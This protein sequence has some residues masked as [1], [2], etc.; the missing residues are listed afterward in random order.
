M[1]DVPKPGTTS[2]DIYTIL[3]GVAA[4]FVLIATVVT[5]VQHYRF[6]GTVIEFGG[7]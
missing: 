4:L 3:I 6:F 1:G 7:I 2:S 5:A